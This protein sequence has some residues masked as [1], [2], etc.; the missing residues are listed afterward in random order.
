MTRDRLV[1][2]IIASAALIVLGLAVEV[3]G[4]RLIGF[5]IFATGI[6]V[7]AAG[8]VTVEPNPNSEVD[9]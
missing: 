5:A 2:T 1:H 7:F 8:I 4:E 3:Y 9:E 6:V